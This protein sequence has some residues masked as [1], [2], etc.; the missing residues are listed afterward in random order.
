[1]GHRA[2]ECHEPKQ[3]SVPAASWKQKSV[4]NQFDEPGYFV[5]PG[6]KR[7][8]THA[9]RAHA[10]RAKRVRSL[11]EESDDVEFVAVCNVKYA[12]GT[13]GVPDVGS[14]TTWR[15]ARGESA[16][17][18]LETH[19][20]EPVQNGGV[21]DGFVESGGVK[22]TACDD[23]DDFVVCARK[24]VRVSAEDELA[25]EL[26]YTKEQMDTMLTYVPHC[27]KEAEEGKEVLPQ[28]EV[29]KEVLAQAE[30]EMEVLAQEEEGKEV[31][32]R[33]E[34]EGQSQTPV[35]SS[36]M[37]PRKSK[38][39]A[40][41][42][43]DSKP[44]ADNAGSS[45]RSLESSLN[46]PARKR[47]RVSKSGPTNEE[48][49]ASTRV[50]SNETVAHQNRAAQIR[51][52]CTRNGG[53]R[54]HSCNAASGQAKVT[55]Q[56]KRCFLDALPL[57]VCTRIAAY[58]GRFPDANALTLAMFSKQ[59]KEAVLSCVEHRLDLTNPGEVPHLE[60]W[61]Q[62]FLPCV[63]DIRCSDSEWPIDRKLF[64]SPT[65][66]HAT[67]PYDE[68]LLLELEMA[69]KL[70]SLCVTLDG[71]YSPRA[72][73]TAL[74]QLKL[75]HLSICCEFCDTDSCAI[76][77]LA[78]S[79]R[80]RRGFANFPA[81]KSVEFS[82][83]RKPTE[84]PIDFEFTPLVTSLPNLRE[85]TLSCPVPE[86]AIGIL[87]QVSSVRLIGI[88][89]GVQSAVKIGPSVTAL[90]CSVGQPFMTGNDISKLAACPKLKELALSIEPGAEFELPSVIRNLEVLHLSWRWERVRHGPQSFK[91]KYYTPPSDVM[92][93]ILQSAPNVAELVLH[94]A[95]LSANQV[96][97]ILSTL[98]PQLR[99][100]G[101]TV[102]SERESTHLLLLLLMDGLRQNCAQLKQL[103][104]K[105]NSSF[106][107]LSGESGYMWS[108][109]LQFALKLLVRRLPLLNVWDLENGIRRLDVSSSAAVV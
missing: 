66:L 74:A 32:A 77:K 100:F 63:R 27:A 45:K 44:V 107:C 59:L 103:D 97:R 101:L 40:S 79:R 88:T 71:V 89:D 82:C 26:G 94:G 25:E 69:P 83:D 106:R 38:Q 64:H 108:R 76:T 6:Y 78:R 42:F 99:R 36:L 17:K 33:E 49:A 9:A 72:L 39:K 104:L 11:M 53:R 5:E 87:A 16:Q 51:D 30:V 58:Y 60:Q 34:V 62:V 1:M 35:K 20:Q 29:E 84:S 67:V 68:T 41:G 31:L 61:E 28:A 75:E 50:P 37:L 10:A 57:E 96:K 14:D 70:R 92:W 85:I 91:A 23:D 102:D 56:R 90:M 47:S 93:E 54:E 21:V 13:D 24:A 3:Q 15:G 18:A 43:Q 81:I 65:L 8:E 52:A 2:T 109:K 86:N 105:F 80:G 4:D 48:I 12:N 95:P 46:A 19:A 98:G 55:V 73:I 22:S 7:E